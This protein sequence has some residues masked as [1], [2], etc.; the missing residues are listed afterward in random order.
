MIS[1]YQHLQ[2][3]QRLEALDRKHAGNIAAH[4][5]VLIAIK[6][7]GLVLFLLKC[8]W[9]VIKFAYKHFV[10]KDGRPRKPFLVKAGAALGSRFAKD[11]EEVC[12]ECIRANK[13]L[14]NDPETRAMLKQVGI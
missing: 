14:A 8:V 2:T 13:V 7:P 11:L 1:G 10:D 6:N 5:L 12:D 9:A 4:P 3:V